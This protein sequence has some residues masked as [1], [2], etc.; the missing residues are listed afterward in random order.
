MP[1]AKENVHIRLTPEQ[2][3]LLTDLAGEYGKTTTEFII[4]M[5]EHV[6]DHR[7]TFQIKPAGKPRRS[8]VK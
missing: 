6:R 5:T 3:Q 7:P 8:K 4:L 1:T 2:K